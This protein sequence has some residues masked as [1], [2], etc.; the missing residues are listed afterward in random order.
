M[1]LGIFGEYL[2]GRDWWRSLGG[3]VNHG[4]GRTKCR[5]NNCLLAE[6]G[7]DVTSAVR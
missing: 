3:E 4:G 5:C 7:L 1:M 2:G 6:I